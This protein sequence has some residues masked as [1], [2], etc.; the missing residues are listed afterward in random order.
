MAKYYK[1]MIYLFSVN[2]INDDDDDDDDDDNDDDYLLFRV[3]FI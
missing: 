1:Y 3:D 2:F